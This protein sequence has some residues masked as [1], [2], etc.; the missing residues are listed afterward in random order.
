[1]EKENKL[2]PQ[3][4]IY[5]SN[6]LSNKKY[7]N[8]FYVFWALLGILGIII[9]I[10]FHVYYNS[11]NRSTELNIN[12]YLLQRK[13][14]L[15]SPEIAKIRQNDIQRQ[16]TASKTLVIGTIVAVILLIVYIVVIIL[17]VYFAINSVEVTNSTITSI[18]LS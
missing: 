3:D 11:I 13:I 5:I 18:Y 12:N 2:T 9:I 16:A 15:Y 6:L 8:G 10:L 17:I 4:T 7:V 14:D 1:M